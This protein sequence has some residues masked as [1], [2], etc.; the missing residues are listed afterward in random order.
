MRIGTK[1]LLFGVH[2]VVLHPIQVAIA[3]NRLYGFPKDPRIWVAFVVHDWGYWGCENMD[4]EEGRRHPQLGYRIMKTLFGHD[5]G[6][7]TRCH[8][9][10]YARLSGLKPST[11]CI[12]DKMAVCVL[13]EWLYLA[14]AV[15]TGELDEYMENGSQNL[16]PNG[17]QG[18][19]MSP[20][21]WIRKVRHYLGQWCMRNSETALP[22]P[23]KK[24]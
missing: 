9:R 1:S 11:L 3:W 16:V 7:W 20:R 22:H 23:G 2:Q 8:S 10:E 19:F 24:T 14:M 6:Q 12:A 17:E 5:W 15:S 4:G 21:E 13:P 18:R